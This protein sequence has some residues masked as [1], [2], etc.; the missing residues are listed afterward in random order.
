MSLVPFCVWQKQLQAPAVQVSSSIFS[1]TL[2]FVVR[3][4]TGRKGKNLPSSV[5]FA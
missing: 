2:L 3:D 5:L 1:E 4:I